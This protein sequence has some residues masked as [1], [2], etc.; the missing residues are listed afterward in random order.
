LPHVDDD[1]DDND[2]GDANDYDKSV[3]GYFYGKK[4]ITK[5]NQIY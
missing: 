1:D 4:Y 3:N 5:S 2:D